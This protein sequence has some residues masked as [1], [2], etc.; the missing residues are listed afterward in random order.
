MNFNYLLKLQKSGKLKEAETGYRKLLK[1]DNQNPDIFTCLGLICIKTKRELEAKNLFLKAVDL[2]SGD[3]TA[4]NNLALIYLKNKK[5][6]D[7]KKYFLK[8]QKINNNS[9]TLF[10]IGLIE[11]EL[12][13]FDSAI[14]YYKESIAVEKN[15]D[16]MCNL[17]NLY[18][19]VGDI[20]KALKY[21]LMS[22]KEN[23]NLDRSYNNLGLIYLAKGNFNLAK[24]NFIKSI[25]INSNNSRAH[26]NLSSI[27]KYTKDNK[28]ID[29]LLKLSNILN[30]EEEKSYIYFALGKVYEDIKN[31]SES[32]RYYKKANKLRRKNIIYSLK[33]ENKL[34][35]YI[36]KNFNKK[37][38]NELKK[39]GHLSKSNIF[40]LGMPRSGTSL[41]EQILATH[42]NVF[43]AGEINFL[44]NTVQNHFML[45]KKFID[46]KEVENENIY[47]AG[48]NYNDSVT[49]LL[50]NK[51]Y[52][53]NKLPAN[54]KWIGLIKI[55]LPNS[56]I[57]H[58]Q[59]N[60]ADICLS[61]FKQNFYTAGNEYSFS[62]DEIIE[63]YNNYLKFMKHWENI[64]PKEIYHLNY[65]N[66]IN[67]QRAEIKKILEFCSLPWENKCMDFA[68]TKR[69]VRTSSHSQVRKKMYQDSI[70][71]WRNYKKFLNK[72]LKKLNTKY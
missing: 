63:Y 37:N 16:S 55:I 43:G 2:N 5:Y 22:L 71:K 31:Y 64:F 59:R 6:N 19:T 4:L 28:H 53:I 58:C 72:Y 29:D 18:Y 8:S 54:F 27:T 44:Q 13:N 47:K 61:I 42:S 60:P 12:N 49:K 68:K 69:I 24:K 20:E 23:P 9:K 17:G 65:E 48:K 66:L 52:I 62:F 51:K 41:I 3:L 21:T 1:N 39:F 34:K 25:K 46:L 45:N 50:K 33:E 10:F 30:L 11:T 35:K 36:I 14:R 38:I 56:K 7:A 15:S 40:V 32:F 57:I 67:N 70:E 26:F